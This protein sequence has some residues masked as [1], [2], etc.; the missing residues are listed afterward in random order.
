LQTCWTPHDQT[1]LVVF[2]LA[3]FHFPEVRKRGKKAQIRSEKFC[4][5]L[6]RERF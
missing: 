3:L 1:V 2:L 6:V 5:F 4:R